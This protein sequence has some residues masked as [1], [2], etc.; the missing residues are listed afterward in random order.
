[1][2]RGRAGLSSVSSQ[3]QEGKREEVEALTLRWAKAVSEKAKKKEEDADSLS[4]QEEEVVVERKKKKKAVWNDEDDGTLVVDLVSQGRLKKLKQRSSEKELTGPAFE[5]RLRQRYELSFG[6]EDWARRRYTGKLETLAG[7]SGPLIDESESR[8]EVS[9]KIDANGRDPSKGVVQAVD[10][11]DTLML[12]ASLD[13]HIRIFRIDGE[14]NEHRLSLYAADLPFYSASFI[15][16][17]KIAASGRRPFFYVFDVETAKATR[18][19]LPGPKKDKQTSLERFAASNDTIAFSMKDGHIK[20]CDTKSGLWSH[21]DLRINGSVRALCFDA[22][23][24]GLLY[25]GGGDGDIYAFDLRMTKRCIHKFQD[26]GRSI[27]SSIVANGDVL[28][29]ASEAGVVNLYEKKDF[30]FRRSIM[31]LTTPIDTLALN[32]DATMLLLSSKWTKDALRVAN[33]QTGHVYANWPTL[34]TPLHYVSCAAFCDPEDY[35]AIGNDRGRVLLYQ[36][37]RATSPPL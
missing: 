20:C 31:N 12:S 19:D 21:T 13:K 8:L 23:Q 6:K 36:L 28:A 7:S 32:N 35:V 11:A 16:K 14:K 10:F 26:Q 1:M 3:E 9:R 29:V 34:K 25:A 27:T 30:L 17:T 4:S 33:V 22:T 37:R 5:D 24:D 2:M 15:Q 18:I